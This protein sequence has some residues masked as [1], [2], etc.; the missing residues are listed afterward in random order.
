MKRALLLFTLLRVT[1]VLNAQ[2]SDTATVSKQS[3]QQ[4]LKEVTVSASSSRMRANVESAQMGKV[5]LPVS[6]LL[7]TPAIGGEADIIKA[8]QLTPGVKRGTEGAIGMYVRGGG[9]DENLILLDGAPLYNAGHLLGF[10][11][12]F[13]AAAL[14]DVQLYKSSF[15]AQYGGRLSSVLDVRT[16]E[17]DMENF[18]A[19]GS[20]GLIS[21]SVSIS[22][23]IIKNRLSASVSGR[24]TY[25]DKVY[26]FIPYHFYDLNAKLT[27]IV[28]DHNR[29]Y[30]S[31]YYGDDVL[32]M[33][34]T[35]TDSTGASFN[36]NSGMNLGNATSSLRWSNSNKSGTLSSDISVLFTRFR[37]QIDGSL[38][39]NA[40]SV[41][42]AISDAGLKGDF[43]WRVAASH[44]MTM[45]FSY[46]Q[47]QFNPNIVQ[48]QGDVTEVI[49]ASKGPQI[50]NSEAGVYVN[51]EWTMSDKWLL[52]GGIRM[53][54]DL[55]RGKTYI[56]PEPR[57][58]ARYLL[59]QR[60]SV[61]FSYARM[62]Q[63]M[64][65]V[66][67][68][69][70]TL[71]TDLWYPVTAN[72]KP[73]LSDQISGGYYRSFNKAGI[74]LSVEAYHKWLQNLIEYREGAQLLLNND[75]EKEMV[76][77]KG[78]S[79]GIEV[80][81]SKTAGKFTG[82]FG[83]SL[84][85][86]RRQFDSL[87]KGKEYFAK[88]DRRHDFSI[89]GVYDLT[90]HWAVSSTVVYSSGS[91]FTGQIGQYAVP[92]PDYTGIE[93]IPVYSDRNALRMSSA[94]RI[95][96]DVAYKFT[97]GKNTKCEAH[98]S[99]YNAL[100]RAQPGRV[101]RV[102]NEEKGMYGYEQKGLFGNVTTCSFNFNL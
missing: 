97:I 72:I 4:L 12:V 56:N 32:G 18:R 35:Q 27:Y 17:G 102:W 30:L 59:N 7:K 90:K 28:D 20:I 38:G 22:T 75:F 58:A 16:K 94:F 100:N 52:N 87:N 42:S 65:L 48:S 62:V 33:N 2:T 83:Y 79:Y 74:S 69:S 70:L 55:A 80:F 66:S 37:Y 96:L 9:N 86:S 29:I 23:P 11:S 14:K 39:S 64:H 98:L 13:N 68:S 51:D 91:P 99:M 92:K 45:G 54:L 60:S 67:S 93:M 1:H 78:R 53:S 40:L 89:V 10:F 76:H 77:G 25:I 31:G 63:Y 3:A 24:R 50:L 73:G 6:L 34:K 21:S 41:R 82:W 5:D 44:K 57:F 43:R 95:D 84:S 26:R 61:K 88:Y 36:L 81:A 46:T 85:Y 71:P 19:S 8:L 49:K 15:P 101:D 47:H